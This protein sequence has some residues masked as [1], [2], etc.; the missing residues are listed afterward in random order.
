MADY[1]EQRGV[2]FITALKEP[3][4][5]AGD[6]KVFSSYEAYRLWQDKQKIDDQ[7]LKFINI[8]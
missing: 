6:R 7:L 2:S 3:V 4:R 5:Q 1:R 8:R